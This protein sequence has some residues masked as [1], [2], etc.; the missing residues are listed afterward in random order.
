MAVTVLAHHAYGGASCSSDLCMC[1]V[2]CIAAGVGGASADLRTMQLAGVA[3]LVAGALSMAC[4]ESFRS[5]A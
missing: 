5:T 4:G 1:F 3:G 2:T